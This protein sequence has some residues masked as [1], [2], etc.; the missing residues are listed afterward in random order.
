MK[1]FLTLIVSFYV[2]FVICWVLGDLEDCLEK[3]D[4]VK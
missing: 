4:E 3:R 2:I 1:L